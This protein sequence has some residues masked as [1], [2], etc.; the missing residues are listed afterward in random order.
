MSTQSLLHAFE[1]L[2]YVD[3][4]LAWFKWEH[5]HCLRPGM[6]PTAPPTTSS[7]IELAEVSVDS[8]PMPH[9]HLSHL[10]LDL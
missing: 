3:C 4:V 9:R 6:S 5:S 10:F 1:L 7:H 2:F 8:E